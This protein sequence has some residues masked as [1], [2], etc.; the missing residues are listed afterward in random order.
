[1]EIVRVL[2]LL[3]RLKSANTSGATARTVGAALRG[4][5]FLEIVFAVTEAMAP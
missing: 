5:P 2:F 1:M 3:E 4:R